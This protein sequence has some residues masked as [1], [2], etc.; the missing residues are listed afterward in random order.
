[1]T[2]VLTP[3]GVDNDQEPHIGL[4]LP[5][6][7]VSTSPNE[8]AALMGEAVEIVKSPR[9]GA[10]KGGSVII[11]YSA[12]IETLDQPAYAAEQERPGKPIRVRIAP[13]IFRLREGDPTSAGQYKAW[14]DVSWIV[15]CAHATDAINLR[16]TLRLLFAQMA[17]H[18]IDLVKQR[19][20]VERSSE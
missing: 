12:N 11:H 4:A 9:A 18:G 16:D 6:P 19:L 5:R 1:M 20:T 17:E 8:L 3:D 7:D 14:T 2:D 10:G 15:E 13:L